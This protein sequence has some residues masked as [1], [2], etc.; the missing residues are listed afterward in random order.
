[1]CQRRLN[2]ATS[3]RSLFQEASDEEV[4]KIHEWARSTVEGSKSSLPFF[5][6]AAAW[7]RISVQRELCN[8]QECD[9]YDSCFFYKAKFNAFNAKIIVVN[10]HL[11]FADLA[12]RD[13][14]NNAA[15]N[16]LLPSYKRLIID[17]A[18]HIEDVATEYFAA[19]VSRLELM[20]VVG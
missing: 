2:E 13:E 11:L 5:P 3:E 20:K 10:H 6:S 18:H 4:F 1:A 14:V 9:F 12:L 7:E 8:A 19:K 17:E 16:T 15:Q